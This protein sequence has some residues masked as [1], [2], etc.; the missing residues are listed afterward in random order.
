MEVSWELSLDTPVLGS[1]NNHGGGLLGNSNEPRDR[2]PIS[3]TSFSILI[4]CFAVPKGDGGTKL[5]VT[6][7]SNMDLSDD[8]GLCSTTQS[9]LF[10]ASSAIEGS[11]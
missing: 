7:L 8:T 6:L 10:N 3:F 2:L 4:E 11:Q 5:A 1:D 9:V